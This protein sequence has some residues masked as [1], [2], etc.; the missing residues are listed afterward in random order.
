MQQTQTDNGQEKERLFPLSL[1]VHGVPEPQGH[2]ALQ[3][4]DHTHVFCS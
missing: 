4:Q 1:P 2:E 3:P